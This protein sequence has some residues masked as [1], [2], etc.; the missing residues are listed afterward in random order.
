[1]AGPTRTPPDDTR[2]DHG[3]VGPTPASTTPLDLP[4]VGPHELGH[5]CQTETCPAELPTFA[6]CSPEAVERSFAFLG[7]ESRPVVDNVDL[8]SGSHH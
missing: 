7:S 2:Q 6:F 1:M 3:R 4:P 5:D 8:H